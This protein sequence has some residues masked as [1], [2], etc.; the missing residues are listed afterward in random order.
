MQTRTTLLMLFV[1]PSLALA[2]CSEDPAGTQDTGDDVPADFQ[3]L[4]LEASDTTGIL[5]GVVIDEAIRPLPGVLVTVLKPGG[6][7]LTMETEDDGL[8]G[9]DALE[10][11]TYFL[12]ATKPGFVP[13]QVSADVVA[14]D[15]SPN[16]VKVLLAADPANAPFIQPHHLDGYITCSLRPMFIAVQCPGAGGNIVNANYEMSRTPTWIQG[17]MTWESTQATGDELSLVVNCLPDEDPAERCQEGQMTIVRDEGLAPRMITINETTAANWTLGG[18]GG[19]P[20]SVSIFVFGRSD[21]DVWDEALIYNAQKPATGNDCLHWPQVGGYPFAPGTCMR[22]TGP[23]L[24]VNQKVDVYTNIFYGFTPN[25]G[26]SFIE[27]G[28]HEVPDA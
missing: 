9:F 15:D 4:G 8:F 26:W 13:T 6:G 18:P 22:A 1:V 11:G 25:E 10:P 27:D 12:T 21:L 20:L 7:N 23:G 17:E 16:A 14:G 28:A 2:G 3:E 24:V 5:R 19:N